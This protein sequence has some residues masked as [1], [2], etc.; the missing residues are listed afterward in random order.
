MKYL[1][2]ENKGVMDWLAFILM[3]ASTKRN[4]TSKIGMFGTGFKYAITTLLRNKVIVIVF[5]GKEKYVFRTKE[6]KLGEEIFNQLQYKTGKLSSWRDTNYTTEMGRVYWTIK[7]A[8]RELAANAIDEL[9]YDFCLTEKSPYGSL[10]K[11]TL[12][13]E[14]HEDVIK[15]Y[16][17]INAFFIMDKKPMFLDSS[18][19]AVYAKGIIGATR[20]YHRGVLA[21]E[22]KGLTSEFDYDLFKMDVKEDRNVSQWE[23]TY[24]LGRLFGVLPAS[25]LTRILESIKSNKT[26]ESTA[27]FELASSNKAWKEVFK[28]KIVTTKDV[29]DVAKEKLKNYDIEIL[30]ERLLSAL[31]DAKH[32]R[33]HRDVL[34]EAEIEGM[35]LYYYDELH[36]AEQTMVDQGNALLKRVGFEVTI[37]IVFF[38]GLEEAPYCKVV[39]GCISINRKHLLLSVEDYAVA[40]I[41]N[42]IKIHTGA[43]DETI[44]NEIAKYIVTSKDRK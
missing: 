38:H 27:Q 40:I 20:V 25:F 5:A 43:T 13:I 29:V 23:V 34:E 4:D 18:I 35:K 24:E 16:N 3:G 11:T 37:K 7:D 21:M 15:F 22:S 28:G 26:L 19:G 2:I 41:N 44:A 6:R 8:I 14:A 42:S 36:D 31:D 17:N 30:P 32:V 33:T 9:Q 39:Q 1:R 12:Y 10:D